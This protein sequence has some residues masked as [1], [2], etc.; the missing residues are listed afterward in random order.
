MNKS[1][2]IFERHCTDLPITTVMRKKLLLIVKLR[3]NPG[4][5]TSQSILTM[6]PR[7]VVQVGAGD[8]WR[9]RRWFVYFHAL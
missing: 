1:S 8:K 4:P 6:K 5:R 9:Q 2:P 3:L 7:W